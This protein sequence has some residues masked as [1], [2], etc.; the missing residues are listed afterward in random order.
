LCDKT[1]H[2]RVCTSGVVRCCAAGRS[3]VACLPLARR[4]NRSDRTWQYSVHPPRFRQL[5]LLPLSRR[6]DCVGAFFGLSL[7]DENS[8]SFFV[9]GDQPPRRQP[10]GAGL[11]HPSSRYA[12]LPRWTEIWPRPLELCWSDGGC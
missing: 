8:R 4:R 9:S 10:L 11:H 2:S 1:R 12:A 7:S 3:P 5:S 6:S